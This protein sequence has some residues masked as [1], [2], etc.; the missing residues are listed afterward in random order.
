MVM[1]DNEKKILD[2]SSGF[3]VKGKQSKEAAWNRLN[4]NVNRNRKIKKM[5]PVAMAVAAA[6]V[7]AL[8]LVFPGET[9]EITTTAGEQQIVYLPD[10]SRVILNSGS[11]LVYSDRNWKNDRHL[12]LDGEAFFEIEKGSELLVESDNGLVRVLGTSFNVYSRT[13]NFMVECF[14]GKVEVSNDKN[15]LILLPN[16]GVR[17]FEGDQLLR[18]YTFEGSRSSMWMKGS[19]GFDDYPLQ[20][21]F[22]ELENQFGFEVKVKLDLS[23]RRYTGYFRHDDLQTALETICLPMELRFSI[24]DKEQQISIQ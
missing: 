7:F 8:L 10:S 4:T 9:Y 1:D 13:S 5:I 16:S 19:S 18:Q 6:I 11:Y 24:D 23:Q 12:Y 15:K 14:T 20:L 3:Q 22:D 21:V 2:R 17:S